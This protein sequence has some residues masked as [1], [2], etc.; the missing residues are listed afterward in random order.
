M[1]RNQHE[2]YTAAE[3]A[4]LKWQYESFGSIGCGAH[5]KR[6]QSSIQ[7][8]AKALGLRFKGKRRSAYRGFHI[9]NHAHPLVRKFLNHVLA[10]GVLLKDV[11]A[12]A[13]IS[14]HVIKN[15]NTVN[16][17]LVNFV[18]AANAVGLELKLV[19]VK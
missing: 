4:V 17:S 14:R 3:D 19:A 10:E 13:G 18:A 6:S 9:S 5:I 7:K 8:R 16:P 15:W 11:S 2:P 1:R 12:R